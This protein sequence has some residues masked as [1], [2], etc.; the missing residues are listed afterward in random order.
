MTLL[1]HGASVGPWGPDAIVEAGSHGRV[2]VY[3]LVGGLLPQLHTQCVQFHGV[4]EAVCGHTGAQTLSTSNALGVKM[5][6]A[7][8]R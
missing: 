4:C 7:R 3:R 6:H 2:G 5:G 1:L 8:C